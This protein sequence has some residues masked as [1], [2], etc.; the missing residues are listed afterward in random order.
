MSEARLVSR[1]AGADGVLPLRV[2]DVH[3]RAEVRPRLDH[4][5]RFQL[6][7]ERV[8]VA[9]VVHPVAVRPEHYRRRTAFQRQGSEFDVA[10]R[11]RPVRRLGN[12]RHLH[13]DHTRCRQ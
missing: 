10:L 12:S 4:D 6:Q 2:P 9:A 11:R 1:R 5:Q 13:D 7:L 3:R 8:A